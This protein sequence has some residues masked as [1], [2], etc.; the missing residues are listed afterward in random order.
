MSDFS[1]GLFGCMSDFGTCIITCF[2][3]CY[4]AA[5]NKATIDERECTFCDF[6]CTPNIYQTRNSIRAKYGY[7]FNPLMDCLTTWICQLCSICQHAAEIADKS[8]GSE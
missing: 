3:P 1:N 2:L 5:N 4:T 6:I 8:G 7:E